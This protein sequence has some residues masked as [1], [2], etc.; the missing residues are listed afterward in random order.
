LSGKRGWILSEAV[1]RLRSATLA[2]VAAWVGIEA[3]A[4]AALTPV[5]SWATNWL[6]GRSGRYAVANKEIAMF[7][8]SPQGLAVVA[9]AALV[10]LFGSALGRA[11]TMTIAAECE[12]IAQGQ[13]GTSGRRAWRGMAVRSG[14]AT[15]RRAPAIAVLVARQLGIFALVLVPFLVVI[16]GIGWWTVRGVELYWVVTTRPARFWMG[17]A[18]IAP[19]VILA[20]CV[21]APLAVRWSLALP[22]CVLE[23]R[24][25]A[26]SMRISVGLMRGRVREALLVRLGW[27]GGVALASFVLSLAVYEASVAVL[28]V[29]FGSLRL[30]A[31][32]AGLV[33]ILSAATLTVESV[34]MRAGDALLVFSMWRR[35]SPDAEGAVGRPRA[36]SGA[37]L[38]ARRVRGMM[39]VCLGVVVLAGVMSARMVGEL[40][41]PLAVEITGHRGAASV[42]PENTIPAVEMA[43]R[44][45]AD[46]AEIDVMLTSDGRL[47]VFHDTDM[48]R[49]AGDP[50]RVVDM[51]LEELRGF[52]VGGWFDPSFAGQRVPTFEELLDALRA[53]TLEGF[54]LNVELKSLRGDEERLA[55]GVVAAL[56]SRGDTG[57]VITS[58]SVPAL[59]A[60]RRIEPERPIGIVLSASLG[61]VS[62]LDVDFYSVPVGV[63]TPAFIADAARQGRGVQVWSVNDAD[64]M[65]RLALRG[66]DGV[67]VHDIPPMR[68]RLNELAELEPL[69][70]L[71][72]AFRTRLLD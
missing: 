35:W 66:V 46:R 24:P 31:F 22:V 39:A 34:V 61:D 6:I 1:G 49:L 51:T 15:L 38:P 9:L 59:A 71:L 33:L 4:A 8:L 45:G 25:P 40:D 67:I 50:R 30:S 62:R 20:A 13:A 27:I 10:A 12:R 65:T 19:V 48:R 64:A 16:A 42:A 69:E 5:G 63:A 32:V 3:S 58:L 47:V 36:A 17:L 14:L 29:E 68:E 21:A 41:R 54:S 52:D 53:S 28:S 44:L 57:C 2:Y 56:R 7:L 18:G 55:A 43:A 70:R 72:L 11:A 37:V 23:R 26:E 60:V